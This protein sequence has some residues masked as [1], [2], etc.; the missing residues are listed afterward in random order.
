MGTS[1]HLH[2][3]ERLEGARRGGLFA[4]SLIYSG[5]LVLGTHHMSM[6]VEYS[7]EPRSTSGGRYHRVTTSLE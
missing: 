7:V 1:D 6:G 3:C 4:S 2:A 5:E